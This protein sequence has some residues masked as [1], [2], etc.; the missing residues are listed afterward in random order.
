M[1]Q[2]SLASLCIP[3]YNKKEYLART[4][5]SVLSQTYSPLEVIVSDNGST[6]GSSEIA[7]DFANRD[8]RVR[9]F[10]LEHTVSINE[11]WRYCWQLAQGDF[12]KL[13]GGDDSTLPPNF[14]E[15]MIEPMLRQPELEFTL[16]AMHPVVQYTAT[17][18]G[19]E[20]QIHYFRTVAQVCREVLALPLRAARARKLLESTSFANWVGSAYPVVCRRSCLP[21]SHWRKMRSPFAWPDCFPDWDFNLRLLL[22]HRGLFVED[23]VA[24]M[25]YDANNAYCRAIVNN[26]YDLYD[27]VGQ[28]LLPLTIL[29]DPE[30]SALRLQA[31]PEELTELIRSVQDRIESLMNLSDEVVAFDHPYFTGRM[32]PRLIQYVDVYRRNPRDWT[33]S[34]RLRQLR[35]GLVQHWLTAPSEQISKEYFAEAGKVHY[36]LLDSGLR[37][38]NLDVREKEILEKTYAELIGGQLAPQ[39]SWGRWLALALL[40]NFRSKPSLTLEMIPDWLQADFSKYAW[41]A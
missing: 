35:M 28:V 34:K 24:H 8:P 18:Y 31:Q 20:I 37:R 11:S 3:V 30:L 27:M 16:C 23:V 7:H 36:L 2:P 32:L 9:Y 39:A 19:P 15:K 17:G 6:D 40:A 29:V 4:L 21:E 41:T 10:R 14:L 12:V 33:A 26:T 25:Y 13:Q 22:N 5:E 1:S 38:A